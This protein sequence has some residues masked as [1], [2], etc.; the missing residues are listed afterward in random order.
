MRS[1]FSCLFIIIFAFCF[2]IASS[3]HDIYI[4][5]SN[6]YLTNYSTQYMLLLPHNIT[7]NIKKA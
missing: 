2:T 6:S 1:L 7:Y 4:Y 5:V 3:L